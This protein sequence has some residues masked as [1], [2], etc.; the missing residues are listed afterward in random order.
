MW[1]YVQSSGAMIAPDG[2]ILRVG[3]S[4]RVPDGKNNPDLQHVR[5]VGPIPRGWWTM[6]APANH[7]SKG[8]VVIRLVPDAATEV[9]GRSG[10]LIHGDN[11]SG[12]ASQGCIIIGGAANRQRIW[13]SG[14]HRL[15]V[16]R[17]TSVLTAGALQSAPKTNFVG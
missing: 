6:S 17:E 13:D 4:G 15:Q 2:E 14:D 5:N 16:V 12:T 11:A 3:Y 9:F 8:P 10:F 1:K 7:P